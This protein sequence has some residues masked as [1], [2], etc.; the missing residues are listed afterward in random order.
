[1]SLFRRILLKGPLVLSILAVLLF[2]GLQIA[3]AQEFRLAVMQ[4]QKGTA[5]K[6]KSLE[7]YLERHG[8]QTRIVVPQS[9]SEAARM[10][11]EGGADGMFSGSGV[12]G[13]MLI[14]KVALP[15]VRPVAT[16]GTSTYWA[17]LV[18]RSGAPKFDGSAAYFKGKR[19]ACCALAS[20]GEF[21]LRAIPGA[22]EAV[23]ELKIVDSHGE[24]ITAV[25]KG[26]ADVAIVKNLVWDNLKIQ[27]PELEL[28]GSD[29]G[30][31]P[32]N[33]LI[34]SVKADPE[35]IKKLMETLLALRKDD[36]AAADAVRRDL[37]IQGYILTSP[38]DFSHT[39]G[40]LQ[41]A[42]VGEDYDFD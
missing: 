4:A 21:F 23:A 25:E 29:F 20:S 24:A 3:E 19:V 36:S 18:A 8:I 17:V 7:A 38:A 40:L 42:G 9:Y 15:L 14:K 5:A 39:L 6:F 12:A 22:R 30:Q 33:T 28:V 37:N 34:V 31:N 16:N 27:Y 32:N 26:A 13:A 35:F 41:R 1:M 2:G 11:A 10:F